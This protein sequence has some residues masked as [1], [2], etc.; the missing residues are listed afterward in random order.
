M[1]D[2]NELT[3]TGGCFI[4]PYYDMN[5]SIRSWF[6]DV[7]KVIIL[8]ALLALGT[9]WKTNRFYLVLNERLVRT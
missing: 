7:M 9:P 6:H 1:M 3:L 5:V 4:L 8:L 2:P